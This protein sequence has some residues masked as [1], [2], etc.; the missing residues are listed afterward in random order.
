MKL[1]L[2]IIKDHFAEF[3]QK[4][5]N[6]DP[7]ERIFI[8]RNG[9]RHVWKGFEIPRTSNLRKAY[10][11]H[12]AIESRNTNGAL[13]NSNTTKVTPDTSTTMK[14]KKPL[15]GRKTTEKP[16][17]EDTDKLNLR[18]GSTVIRTTFYC[19]FFGLVRMTT[20]VDN[21][22]QVGNVTQ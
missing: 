15:R 14:R 8:D 19:P 6:T 1:T 22:D 13:V 18:D 7:S 10:I 2:H 17:I 5:H 16:D 20:H 9:L 11:P 4:R 12:K 21:F 3:I